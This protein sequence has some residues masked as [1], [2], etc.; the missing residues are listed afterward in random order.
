[1]ILIN[2][3]LNENSTYIPGWLY[4]YATG[5]ASQHIWCLSQARISWEGC[6]RNG[7]QHK[8]GGDGRGRGTN[9]SGRVAVHLDCWYMCLCYLHFASENPEDGKS[10]QA[11]MVQDAQ[12]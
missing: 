2:C 12:V 5:Y 10:V 7:I 1:M 9:Q 11:H 6:A 4:M 8:K 3:P